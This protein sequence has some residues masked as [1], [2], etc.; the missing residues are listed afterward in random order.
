VNLPDLKWGPAP[1]IFAKGAQMAVVSGDTTK[2]GPFVIRLRVPAGYRFAAR[3]HPTNEYVTI[4]GG[5]M[6]LGMGDKLDE[7][8]GRALKAGGLAMARAYETLRLVHGRD[9]DPGLG[10]GT[11]RHHPRQPGG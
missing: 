5:D 8:K 11:V 7:N 1:P 6:S 10:R 3:H 9:V 2:S 4:I